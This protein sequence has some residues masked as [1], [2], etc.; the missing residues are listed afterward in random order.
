[1]NSLTTLRDLFAPATRLRRLV[2][3]SEPGD[4]RGDG[5]GGLRLAMP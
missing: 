3:D 2:L 5:P 1:M 4:S